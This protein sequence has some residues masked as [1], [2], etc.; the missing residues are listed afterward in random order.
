MSCCGRGGS[1]FQNCG[2]A[3]NRKLQHTWYEGIQACKALT[4]PR[5]VVD[6][7]ANAA[8]QKG[9]GSSHGDNK[10]N[11][12]GVITAAKSFAF[13]SANMSTPMADTTL[14]IITSSAP[15]MF[16]ARATHTMNSKVIAGVAVTIIPISI[17]MST[18]S[19]TSSVNMP[20]PSTT[21]VSESVI[22]HACGNL[23]NI[24][25]HINLLVVI[26]F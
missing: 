10:V 16:T 1:W 7:E 11:S 2:R 25:L 26:V 20:T 14:T 13:T 3:G 18:P 19:I 23:M 12:K 8:Q 24:A 6:Q 15:S 9:I 17:D 5:I 22:T 4:Q 21:S